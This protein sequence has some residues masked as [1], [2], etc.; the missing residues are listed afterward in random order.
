MVICIP[1]KYEFDWTKCFQVGVRKRKWTNRWMDRQKDKNGQTNEQNF[2]N[3][4]RNLAMMV[5]YVPVKFEFDWT[6]RF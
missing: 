5:M 3:F 1:V 2:T 4:D 6:N